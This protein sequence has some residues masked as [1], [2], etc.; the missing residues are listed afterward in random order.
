MLRRGAF[1][2]CKEFLQIKLRQAGNKPV[3]P[4]V[5]QNCWDRRQNQ[6]SQTHLSLLLY[7]IN[8]FNVCLQMSLGGSSV[9]VVQLAGGQFQV[10]G[11]IQSAQP[12]V[13]QSPHSQ[14]AQVKPT[15]SDVAADAL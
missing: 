10:Q 6:G 1:S 13:I 3:K 2:V 5:R 14:A 4:C 8:L 12:S 7:F 15:L 9:A 11:V